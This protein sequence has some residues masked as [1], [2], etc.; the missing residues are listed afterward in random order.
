MNT[1]SHQQNLFIYGKIPSERDFVRY[2]TRGDVG[3]SGGQVRLEQWLDEGMAW[4]YEH[5]LINHLNDLNQANR[6]VFI[7]LPDKN[8]KRIWQG[9]CVASRD[10]IGRVFPVVVA[11][12]Q[13]KPGGYDLLF[14]QSFASFQFMEQS[15]L[16]LF[17]GDNSVEAW[18]AE[19]RVPE[20][21]SLVTEKLL[22]FDWKQP[23]VEICELLGY[24]T[25]QLAVGMSNL[26]TFLALLP[27]NLNQEIQLGLRIDRLESILA[28]MF[29]RS[30]LAVYTPDDV[31]P[32]VM[33]SQTRDQTFAHIYLQHM[34]AEALA[35]LY[36]DTLE[37]EH[38]TRLSMGKLWNEGQAIPKS[39]HLMVQ[40]INLP[41]DEWLAQLKEHQVT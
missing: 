31:S 14:A 34:P 3:G 13:G 7:L 16:Q 27:K 11:F 8:T 24:T 22:A 18:A 10:A 4:I 23:V 9:V 41:F 39:V 37:S 32:T 28:R 35:C 5:G 6:S 15:L 2:D 25:T 17:G 38:I 20:V 19:L 21:D 29:W 36:I 30:L 1:G 26:S 12:E 40:K 33:L